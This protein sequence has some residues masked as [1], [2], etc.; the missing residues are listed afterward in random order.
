MLSS[1]SRILA[2]RVIQQM[3]GDRRTLALICI[4]PVILLSFLGILIRAEPGKLVRS[5]SNSR[6]RTRWSRSG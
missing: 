2:L 6:D 4:V 3:R 5:T 1:R